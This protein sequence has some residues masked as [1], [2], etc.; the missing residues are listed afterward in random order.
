MKEVVIIVGKRSN[1]S[2]ALKNA[3]D[4]VVL[5]SSQDFD[6]N[7]NIFK[8][9]R[10]N[11]IILIFNNFQPSKQLQNKDF[12]PLKYINNS[13]TTTAAILSMISKNDNIRKI[14]Y[15]SSASVYGNNNLSRENDRLSPLTLQASLKIANEKMIENYSILSNIDYTITRIFNMYGGFES[16][17]VISKIIAAIK[18]KSNINII[19][20]G[21]AIRDYIHI[22]DVVRVYKKLIVLRKLKFIN[23]ASGVGVSVKNIIDFLKLNDITV[24]FHNIRQEEIKV[25]IASTSKLH[26][27]VDMSK[28]IK[29]EEFI[30]ESIDTQEN[31]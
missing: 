13:I 23:I 12:Q 27:L 7:K 9:Y 25:S 18:E 15:T 3:L 22:D 28:F 30:L 6:T 26:T 2:L 17:S 19:N 29:V 20:N 21:N 24:N 16:F 5:I 1:L 10:R 31:H 8:D 14:I 4:N 11:E